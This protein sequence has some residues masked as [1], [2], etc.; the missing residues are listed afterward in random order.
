MQELFPVRKTRRNFS[1]RGRD[2]G[3]SCDRAARLANP[4]LNLAK[5]SGRRLMP[6]N[7]RHEF[8][9]QLAGKPDAKRKFLEARDAV[10]KSHY[11]IANFS[12]VL[13]TAIHD[14]SRLTCKQLTQRGLCALN[15][16][17]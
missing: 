16:A 17:R 11:I 2:V 12:K 5:T 14:G 9:V 4:I 8:F 10:L 15:L 6:P 13:G 1:W 7:A 3:S